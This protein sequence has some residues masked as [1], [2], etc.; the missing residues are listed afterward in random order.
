MKKLLFLAL[1]GTAAWF[2]YTRWWPANNPQAFGGRLES[3]VDQELTRAG[4]TDRDVVNQARRERFQWGI[5]W[6][7]SEKTLRVTNLFRLQDISNRL[8]H[9]S[10]RPGCSV[11]LVTLFTVKLPVPAGRSLGGIAHGSCLVVGA[12]VAGNPAF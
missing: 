8:A 10:R 6:I 11:M 9:L 5:T 1:L 7:E 3:T 4:F 2:L 12:K